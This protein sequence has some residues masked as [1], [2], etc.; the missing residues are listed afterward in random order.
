MI[1]ILQQDNRITKA[2][3]AVVIGA[4]IVTMVITLVPG[5]FNDTTT[6]D[7]GVYASVRSPGWLGKLSGDSTSIQTADV[8]RQ[9]EQQ[10]QQQN[11]PPFYLQFVMSRAGQI[12]VERAVLQHEAD[13]LGLEVSN[14][15]L[16]SFLKSGP[17]AQYLFPNGNFIGEDQYISF[18]ETYF[19]MPIADF[20]A[21]V[22]SDLEIQ[23]LQALVTGGVT[24]SDAAVKAEYLKTGTK[25]KFD[26]AVISAASI[27]Q[28]INPS[29]SDLQAFLKQNSAR[30]ATAVPEQRKIQF[31][32]FDSSNLPGGG[33]SAVSDA[34]VQAYFAAHQDTYKVPEQVKTRHILISVAKG[35]DAK[36]DA[37]AKAKA[38][39]ILKQ[40]KS[41]GD[42]ADLA[43][44][45]SEDPGSK[46]Q[47]GDLPLIATSGLDPA[48]AK[49]AMALNPGQTSDVVRSQF[50][51]HIIQTEQK[52]PASVKTLA[53][54]KP[55]I[56]EAIQVQKS[57][58]AAQTF[59]T[60]LV[61]EAKKEWHPEDRRRAQPP[62]ADHR[63]PRSLRHH[64]HTARLRRS[65]HRSLRRS[66]GC[67]SRHRLHRRRLRSLPSRR[68]AGCSRSR[69]RRL[70]GASSRRLPPGKDT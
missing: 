36:T 67:R 26:Y 2:I 51:Y 46:D 42:F 4:A 54:V 23:R 12:Q 37:A 7:A 5:I 28:T 62:R 32:S 68:R 33:T 10:M 43:R 20:E 35:A 14:D 24:V 29:D 1:R 63:L 3:F 31:F 57:G 47:G 8:Q 52:Q 65:A 21:Q 40:I 34:E 9:A 56:V 66:Q 38:E 6:T 64:L 60:Q 69:L 11:L 27:S 25:V 39:G 19:R 41:G 30:Y 13:R 44:K 70:Q 58:A 55:S 45:N 15:D 17:Y 50:G 49:A 22:K 59:G 48:Y 53:E 18:V 16:K 61:A